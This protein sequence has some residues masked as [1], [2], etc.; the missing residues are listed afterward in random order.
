MA[1]PKSMITEAELDVLKVL[2]REQPLT[3]R[4]LTE[5]LYG[6]VNRSSLGTVQKLVSRL[7]EKEMVLRDRSGTAHMFLA[8][9]SREE[10]AGMQLE[11]FANKLSGGSL[12]PFVTHLVRSRRLSN[13]EKEE[14]RRLLDE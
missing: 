11:E 7:Q 8:A 12:S 10:V 9:V 1:V 6:E 5:Q 13:R 4:E 14:I 2:W 3:S